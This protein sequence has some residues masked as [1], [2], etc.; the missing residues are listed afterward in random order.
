MPLFLYEIY[1]IACLRVVSFF[2]HRRKKIVNM[3][4]STLNIKK[5]CFERTLLYIWNTVSLREVYIN[6]RC[7]HKTTQFTHHVVHHVE[8]SSE[9]RYE[10]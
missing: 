7:K 8:R 2:I 4:K 1:R 5:V 9:I 6:V 10:D 3:Q